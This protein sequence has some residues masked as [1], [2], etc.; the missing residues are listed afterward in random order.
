[1]RPFVAFGAVL[2]ALGAA[3]LTTANPASAA[4]RECNGLQICVPV[5]GPWVVVPTAG[6]VRQRV[7]YQLDCPRGYIVGGLDAELSTQAIDVSFSGT[8][9]SPVN[10]GITTSG[11]AVFSA[12]YVGTDSR[13]AAS[14]RPHI[15]CIPTSGGGGR[16]PTAASAVFPPGR[17]TTRRVRN[18]SAPARR[19]DRHAGVRERRAAHRRNAR[20]RLLHP[21]AAEREPG[22]GGADATGGSRLARDRLGARGRGAGGRSRRDPGRRHLRRWEMSFVHPFLLLTLLAVPGVIVAHAWLQRRRARYAVRFTNIDV[23]ASVAGGRSWRHLIPL[24]LFVAALA[25]L[26]IGV[27]RPQARTLVPTDK[28]TVILVLDQSG[29][30]FAQDIRPTRLGAAQAAVRTFLDKAPKRIRVG[31]VVFAGEAQVAT[32]PTTDHELVRASVDAL[33]TFPESPGTAIGDA[34]AAAVQVGQEALADGS[35]SSPE[36]TTSTSPSTP[37]SGAATTAPPPVSVL[38]LSDGSQTRGVL[39]P[40]EGAARA[41]T[42][43][44]PVYTIALGTPDGTITRFFGGFQRTIPV[45]PDPQTLSAIAEE[46]GGK[47]F[48]ARSAEAVRSAY[49]HLGTTL[50]RVPG[51]TEV[52][53]AFLAVA[54][55]LLVAAG[56][57]AALWGP[58]LP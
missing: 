45:P 26:C 31:L 51:H 37:G 23:L 41:K 19:V 35:A 12:T 52:T 50:G 40:L 36:G 14:V 9:G 1:M 49:A 32:P 11:S 10:P 54:S 27:A 24:A 55:A 13:A 17:P 58:R 42:A 16:T 21:G 39:Q 53:Y 34:I 33:G 29:S 15:G 46:T 6:A 20:D 3:A 38:F 57:L 48:D 4:T 47:F 25:A 5:A 30:M 2:L 56:V 18:C 7:E 44:I 22:C 28:A 43:R 8:M